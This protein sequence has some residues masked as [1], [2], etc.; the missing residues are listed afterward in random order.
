MHLFQT[1]IA[2][3]ISEHNITTS[4][5]VD[6]MNRFSGLTFNGDLIVE[7]GKNSSFFIQV[8]FTVSWV[9]D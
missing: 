1:T 4:L 5:Q 9:S 7:R 2:N 3:H 8:S 6:D